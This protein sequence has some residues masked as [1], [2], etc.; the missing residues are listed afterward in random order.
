MKLLLFFL[1]AI[2]LTS[3][4]WHYADG[5]SVWSK[6]LWLAPLVPFLLSIMFFYMAYKAH[7]SG[8]WKNP[9][10]TGGKK[11]EGGIVPYKEI[12]QFWLGVACIIAV[13]V[14]LIWIKSD[15]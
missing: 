5:T 8:S 14:I 10:D 13:I 6:Q 11:V 4:G 12:P 9:K 15:I 3:C 1:V 7:G 2:L